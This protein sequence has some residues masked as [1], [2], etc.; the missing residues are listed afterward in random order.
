[1]N[2]PTCTTLVGDCREL[3]PRIPP[4]SIHTCITSPPYWGLRDYGVDG[5][6]GLE[7]SVEKFVQ[8]LVK[9]FRLVRETLR[10]DGTL[11]LNLGDTYSQGNRGSVGNMDQMGVGTRNREDCQAA[12]LKM[13]PSRRR[14]R[15]M[16]PDNRSIAVFQ[17]GPKQLLGIPWRVALA[18]Q[19]DGW[20]LRQDIIWS[21]PN[22]MPE[23]VRDRCTKSHEYLFLLS[24]RPRYYWDKSAMMEPA[25]G[26]S[27]PRG[28]GVNP[29]AKVPTGWDT[30]PGSHRAMIGRYRAKQN[31]SF[32]AAVR[33]VVSHRNRRSVWTVN[34]LAFKERHFATFPP[35]LIAPCVLAT[36][37]P[38][39]VVL[40]PFG[41]SGTVG[42]VATSNGRSAILCELN[43]DYVQM[44]ARR[45]HITPSFPG[46]AS[47]FSPATTH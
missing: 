29:K 42:L 22:P 10:A 27:R 9:V 1:M 32:S 39:G 24:K 47:A 36:C 18:L 8:E 38:G 35:D 7:S 41:G 19:A 20:I 5:Q 17:C 15:A 23:S 3:L 25:A 26:T 43:P 11:W 13:K 21:K 37:P 6:I 33:G 4:G 31:P 46:L 44:I 34:P 12:M 28:T 14:D 40:D 45:T 30:G 2:T 16:M